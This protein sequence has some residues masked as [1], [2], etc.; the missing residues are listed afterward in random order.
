MPNTENLIDFLNLQIGKPYVLGADGPL[1]YDCSGLI[2]SAFKTV[3]DLDLPRQSTAQFGVGTPVEKEDLKV[4]DLVFFDT[5]WSDRK[6]NHLG[7]VVSPGKMIN[8]NSYSG[9]VVEESFTSTYWKNIYM[10]SRRLLSVESPFDDMSIN[11]DFFAYI[12]DLKKRNI[13]EGYSLL[14]DNKS[15]NEFR[16]KQNVNRAELLKIAALAFKIN[17]SDSGENY[18][19]DVPVDVWYRKYV[20]SFKNLGLISGYPDGNFR[21]ESFVNRA[22]ALKIL[23][24]AADVEFLTDYGDKI[25]L[26]VAKDNWFYKYAGFCF[27]NNCLPL[28]ADYKLRPQLYLTRAEACMITSR[29]LHLQ[30]A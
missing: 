26:D 5:G 15:V 4:G 2:C 12:L 28:E 21:P 14:I 3:F 7:V 11:D 6:P 29:I 22:E 18:F 10:G 25:Y 19:P 9:S 27:E 23:L 8:A 16:P 30:N 20:N 24:L 13:I 1:E 17:I